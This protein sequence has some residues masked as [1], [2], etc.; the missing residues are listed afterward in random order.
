MQPRAEAEAKGFAAFDRDGTSPAL[1]HRFAAEGIGHEHAVVAVVPPARAEVRRVGHQRDAEA[2]SG[3]DAGVIA[4]RGGLAPRRLRGFHAIGAED[5]ATIL[6][7]KRRGDARAET[8][9]LLV[10]EGELVV[11]GAEGRVPDEQPS[12]RSRRERDAIRERTNRFGVRSPQAAFG[13]EAE[14]AVVDRRWFREANVFDAALV[15]PEVRAADVAK[16]EPEARVHRVVIGGVLAG[17]GWMIPGYLS[18]PGHGDVREVRTQGFVVA[19]DKVGHGLP[20]VRD[21]ES[22]FVLL[23]GKAGSR[24]WRGRR[25]GPRVGVLLREQEGRDVRDLLRTQHLREGRHR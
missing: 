8:H 17:N 7:G 21:A 10:P 15:A 19:E 11:V 23:K 6:F 13:G 22:V 20:G 5:F 25:Y 2:A 24:R 9:F 18:A 4:P 16:R 12:A 14:P 3:H 1:L